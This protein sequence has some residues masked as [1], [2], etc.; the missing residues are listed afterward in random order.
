M[1]QILILIFFIPSFCIATS[2][3]KTISDEE[4]IINSNMNMTIQ[5]KESDGP[6]FIPEHTHPL[7]GV[8]YLL[9]GEV[10][11]TIEEVKKI[12]KA[13]DSWTEPKD[14]IHSGRSKGPIK[15]FVVYHHLT[16]NSYIN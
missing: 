11:V 2:T 9:K 3:I 1:K 5:I 7:P 12:Y 14:K 10:E 6:I 4:V 8:V 15:Y 16:G 13:G